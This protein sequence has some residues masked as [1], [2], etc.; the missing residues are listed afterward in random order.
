MH[1]SYCILIYLLLGSF[2]LAPVCQTNHDKNG[3]RMKSDSIFTNEEITINLNG[4]YAIDSSKHYLEAGYF[5]LSFMHIRF[6]RIQPQPE[7]I[8]Q[9]SS[10]DNFL[11]SMY[12]L[13]QIMR[14]SLME[15]IEKSFGQKKNL[16]HFSGALKISIGSMHLLKWR[17]TIGKSRFDH[18][19]VFGN[20]FNYLFISSPYGSSGYIEHI[21]SGMRF[22]E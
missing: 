15:E 19:L 2:T 22:T 8:Q 12:L 11:C 3:S 4:P 10:T 18:Y 6:C 20:K 14:E 16:Y 9:I 13:P 5:S 7:Y 1:L 21:I 17:Q